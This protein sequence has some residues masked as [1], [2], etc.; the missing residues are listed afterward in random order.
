MRVLTDA[1][2][3]VLSAYMVQVVK[4]RGPFLGLSDFVNRRLRPGLDQAPEAYWEFT[5]AIQAAIDQATRRNNM[6]NIG[7]E[8]NSSV[9]IARNAD[10][11]SADAGM[12][13]GKSTPVS[14]IFTNRIH[15][16]KA[17]PAVT[18][19]GGRGTPVPAKAANRVYSKAVGAPGYLTQADVLQHIGGAL[20]S[21]SDTFTIRAMGVDSDSGAQA[22]VELTVQ[23]MVDAVVPYQPQRNGVTFPTTGAT[24]EQLFGR[25]F[26]ILST[27]WLSPNAL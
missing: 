27:R 4:S 2:I 16:P 24:G 10:S 21:R 5:G 11:G 19:G 20:S 7:L 8:P 6:I 18:G 22:A 12:T 3:N 9:A 1:E 14:G 25:R 26:V 23:R 17:S 15:A 13:D